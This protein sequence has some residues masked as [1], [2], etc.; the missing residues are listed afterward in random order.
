[1]MKP[2]VEASTATAPEPI[3][4]FVA[5]SDLPKPI[6]DLIRAADDRRWIANRAVA[7]DIVVFLTYDHVHYRARAR[8]Y[9]RDAEHEPDVLI[10]RQLWAI[11]RE[12]RRRARDL[13]N[14]LR[15]ILPDA[16][17]I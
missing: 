8:C 10:R 17:A 7:A 12:C 9:A 13:R 11:S 15:L 3:G 5:P 6:S 14:Q 2:D 4:G 16:A 1:M